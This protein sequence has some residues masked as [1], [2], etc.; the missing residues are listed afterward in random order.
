MKK[1]FNLV[2][3]VVLITVCS[4]ALFTLTVAEADTMVNTY[5][6][7]GQI[8][9]K[10]AMAPNGKF[11]ITWEGYGQD[12]GYGVYAQMYGSSGTAVGSEFRVNSYIRDY[13]DQPSIAIDS[14]GNFII[15]WTRIK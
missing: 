1:I 3:G 10:V 7:D 13:Q 4:E 11:V 15:T 8:A 6:T 12:D 2:I 5:T 14:N 9:P